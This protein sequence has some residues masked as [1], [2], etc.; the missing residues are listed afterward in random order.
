MSFSNI[1]VVRLPE[2][3]VS[4]VSCGSCLGSVLWLPRLFMR[5]YILENFLSFTNYSLEKFALQSKLDISYDPTIHSSTG[6]R[7]SRTRGP[8]SVEKTSQYQMHL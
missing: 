6:Q 1:C 3:S 5:L 8:L 7:P 4:R 2:Y